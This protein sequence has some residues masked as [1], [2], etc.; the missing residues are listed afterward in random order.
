MLYLIFS[1]IYIVALVFLSIY[2]FHALFLSALYLLK[3]KSD[4][5]KPVKPKV[6]PAVT[7]QLPVYNEKYVIERLIDATCQLDYPK[8]KLSIQILDDSTDET[9]RFARSRVQ[10]YRKQGVNVSLHHR[11]DRSGFKA[12]AL[13]AALPQVQGDFIAIV[14]ADFLPK[15]DFLKAL[16]P[17]LAADPHLG[18]IQARWGHLNA[19]F[20]LLTRSQ[21]M[22]I[23]AHFV[24]EQTARSRSGLLF[25][26]NGS[27]GIWRKSCIIDSGGWQADTLT[28]DLDLSYRAQLNGWQIA[29]LPGTIVPGELPIQIAAFEKQQYR[30]A[31]GTI[32][33]L[34]KQYKSLYRARHISIFQR[35]MAFLHLSGYLTHPM[36]LIFLF[37]SLPVV[38]GHG[39]GLPSMPWITL[40]G[41]G[42][43]LIF[44][45]SQV[46]VYP[47][48]F[49]RMVNLPVLVCLGIGVA[50][51]NTRAIIA[52]FR[53]QTGIFDRTPKY[54][55]GQRQDGWKENQYRL[56]YSTNILG[57]FFLS[58]YAAITLG[59]AIKDFPP[60]IP[61]LVMF[62]LSFFYVG[63]T[64][65][66]HSRPGHTRI[67]LNSTNR[68]RKISA[69]PHLPPQPPR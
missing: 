12:G 26:F 15:R 27:G 19:D 49:Q 58:I 46:S 1:K 61:V 43:P 55:Y 18:M 14:D 34:R 62:T 25:N 51:N 31:R 33:V 57:E 5:P 50:L 9:T 11:K 35:L 65:L 23:D 64:G 41:F 17:Y 69:F 28:E 21:A 56:K 8:A 22:L 67:N 3:R 48:W 4:P 16:I 44:G 39:Q 20:N 10:H 36:M 30:W 13:A 7:V 59:F 6:W 29:Y 32:Q 66:I 63:V 38:L 53:H 40:A 54:N 68:N 47:D 2:G 60:L 24:V 42:A 37:A 45:L 52:G